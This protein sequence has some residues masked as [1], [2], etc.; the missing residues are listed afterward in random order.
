MEYIRTH[1]QEEISLTSLSDALSLSKYHLC[2]IFKE[3]TGTTIYNHFIT[4][5]KKLTGFTPKK[6]ASLFSL[7]MTTSS[8]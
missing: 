8:A 3:Q 5:F 7:I 6:Y 4:T 2:H 1:L